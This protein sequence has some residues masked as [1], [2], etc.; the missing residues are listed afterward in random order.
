M[1]EF[2]DYSTVLIRM[3]NSCIK[4]P[5]VHLGI[6]SATNGNEARV[7]FIQNMEYKLVE[8]LYCICS[9][10][11]TEVAQNHIT[12]RYNAMKQKLVIIKIYSIY[13]ISFN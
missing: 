11:P 7:D 8:L 5:H 9:R 13:N 12:F 6:F 3:L 10:S 1:V 2:S 4:E